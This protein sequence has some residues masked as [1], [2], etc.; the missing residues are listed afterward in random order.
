MKFLGLTL[1]FLALT[2][3]FV[4][5]DSHGAV[6]EMDVYEI[7]GVLGGGCACISNAAT[8]AAPCIIVTPKKCAYAPLFSCVN[9]TITCGV[10]C[11]SY[12]G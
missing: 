2:L 3:A 4:S 9:G 8:C 5:P 10:G 1:V 12:C 7:E 6:R 11:G